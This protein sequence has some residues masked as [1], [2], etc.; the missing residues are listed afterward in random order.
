MA[1]SVVEMAPAERKEYVEGKI[2]RYSD[3]QETLDRKVEEGIISKDDK[4]K[5]ISRAMAAR[6]LKKEIIEYKAKKDSLTGLYNRDAFV[7]EYA[8]LIKS[9]SKF[10][11]LIVDLDNFGDVNNKYTYLA[12]NSVI[13]QMG[14]NFSNNLR[15]LRE[16]EDENDFI[17]RWGGDEFVIIL[18]NIEKT[19]NLQVVTEKFKKMTSERAFAVNLNGVYHDVPAEFSMGAAVYRG[20]EKDAFFDKVNSALKQA[21]TTGKNKAVVI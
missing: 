21:K 16:N 20:E 10:A 13:A 18:K 3:W 5:M 15:Q 2:D 19:E 11:L 12:G 8:K 1:E 7:Q 4:R 14:L 9:G 17:C 6:D